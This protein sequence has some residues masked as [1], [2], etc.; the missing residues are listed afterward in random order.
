MCLGVKGFVLILLVVCFLELRGTRELCR[1]PSFVRPKTISFSFVWS[2]VTVRC[3]R[4]HSRMHL[5]LK[6]GE[7]YNRL[8]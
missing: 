2:P 4:V 7:G 1:S 5:G 3:V 8:E 6:G